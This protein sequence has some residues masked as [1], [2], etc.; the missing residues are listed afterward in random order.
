MVIP[1]FILHDLEIINISVTDWHLE[2]LEVP[3][4][5]KL[6][7]Y[8]VRLSDVA[9]QSFLIDLVQQPVHHSIDLAI[10]SISQI[11]PVL[12]VLIAAMFVVIIA[13]IVI[14]ASSSSSIVTIVFIVIIVFVVIIASSFWVFDDSLILGLMV[15]RTQI[16]GILVDRSP[17]GGLFIGSLSVGFLGVYPSAPVSF[18]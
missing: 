13:L 4:R 8:H 3:G 16:G 5:A 12:G 7:C 9:L 18:C 1:V 10:V 15:D 6:S 2:V 17:S 14:I 11:V